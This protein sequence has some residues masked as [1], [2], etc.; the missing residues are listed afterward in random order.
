MASN[1]PLDHPRTY[2]SR[3]MCLLHF[4]LATQKHRWNLGDYIVDRV[5]ALS[6]IISKIT[7]GNLDLLFTK[8][9]QVSGIKHFEID[10]FY[11]LMLYPSGM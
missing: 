7:L 1:A 6:S 10:G 2:W 8:M 4:K 5:M 3:Q 11:D 9:V